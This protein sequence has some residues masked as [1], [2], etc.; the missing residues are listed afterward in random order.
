MRLGMNQGNNVHIEYV[1][2][3]NLKVTYVE[4]SQNNG[5]FPVP[6]ASKS[7]AGG[8]VPN[9]FELSLLSRF[10]LSYFL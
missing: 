5:W 8:V 2:G 4:H 9:L 6:R 10:F 7:R 3:D 1:H